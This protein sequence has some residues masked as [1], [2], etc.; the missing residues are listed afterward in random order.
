MMM[1]QSTDFLD[2]L[3][4][5]YFPSSDLTAV[6]LHRFESE[7]NGESFTSHKT[8]RMPVTSLPANASEIASEMNFLPARTSGTTLA[9]ISAEPKLRTGGRPMTIPD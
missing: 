1:M 9:F 2:P 7:N 6:V 4:V 5:Q 3:I 8:H